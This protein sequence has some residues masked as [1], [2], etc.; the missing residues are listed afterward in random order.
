MSRSCLLIT[1]VKVTGRLTRGAKT[2]VAMLPEK[3]LQT[4]KVFVNKVLLF[5]LNCWSIWKLS[6]KSGNFSS[7]L[8]TVQATWKVS[9]PCFRTFIVIAI[10]QINAL[11]NWKVCVAE[12]LLP[13]KFL[14]FPA[15][16]FRPWGCNWLT[17]NVQ[18]WKKTLHYRL[19]GSINKFFFNWLAF[20]HFWS[21]FDEFFFVLV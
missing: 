16:N 11:F 7:H 20:T 13:G 1:S 9:R 4:I 18:C 12:I 3:F 15:E 14:S 17:H 2:R 8:E 5:G 10:K 21:N 19:R 6:R